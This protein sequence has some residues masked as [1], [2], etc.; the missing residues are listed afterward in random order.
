MDSNVARYVAMTTAY[1][2]RNLDFMYARLALYECQ[3]NTLGEESKKLTSVA[4]RK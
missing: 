4:G 1:P 3:P 2:I